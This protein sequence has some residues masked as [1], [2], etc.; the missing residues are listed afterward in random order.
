MENGRKTM[1]I[2][3]ANSQRK[4]IIKAIIGRLVFIAVHLHK[5]HFV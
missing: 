2:H 1:E 4:A 3:N 5:K